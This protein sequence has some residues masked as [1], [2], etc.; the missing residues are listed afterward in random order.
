M[1]NVRSLLPKLISLVEKVENEKIDMT[2][3]VEVWE[4]AGKKNRSFPT[5][6]EEVMEMKGLKY[7]SCGARPSGKRGGGAAI[8]VKLTQH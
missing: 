4:K 6:T 7:I 8:L 3:L 1:A 5:K 2:L